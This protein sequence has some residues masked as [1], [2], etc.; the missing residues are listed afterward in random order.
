MKRS[1]LNEIIKEEITKIMEFGWEY[2]IGLYDPKINKEKETITFVNDAEVKQ[3][4]AQL[5]KKKIN[6]KRSGKTLKF[7][8]T[9]DFKKA[10]KIIK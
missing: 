4:L 8:N 1:R 2:D 10:Q 6:A 5:K 7:V 3:A 9:N